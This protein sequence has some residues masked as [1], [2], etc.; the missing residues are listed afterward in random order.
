M[1]TVFCLVAAVIVA[2]SYVVLLAR[3]RKA[4]S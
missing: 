2:G 3:Y 1:A 4:L